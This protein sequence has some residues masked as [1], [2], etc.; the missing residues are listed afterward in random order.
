MMIDKQL[1]RLIR[2]EEKRQKEG[3]EMIPSEN[4]VSPAV[5]QALGSVLTNKYSEGYPGKRYYGGNEVIDEIEIL[6]LERAKKL[7]RVPHANVQPYSGSPANWA[8]HGALCKPHEPILSQHLSHGG[9]LS[10]GQAA[11]LSS[12][13]Y[14]AYYYGL[15]R[16]GEVDFAQLESQAGKIKPKIIWAGGT[17]YSKK[18]DWRRLGQIA[19]KIGAFFVADIAHIAGLVVGGAHPSPV[20]YAHVVTTTTHKTLRGPR[21]GMILVTK[22]GLKKDPD[23]GQKIDRAVFPGLQGGPHD[24]QIAALAVALHEAAQ[25]SFKNYA[26]QIVKNAKSLA[27]VFKKAGFVLVGGGTENHMVWVD[28]TNQE[29]DGWQAQFALEA[30]GISVN[31]QTVPYDLRSAYYP[32]GIRLGTPALTTRGMKEKEVVRIA[33]WMIEAL[34]VARQMGFTKIGSLDKEEDQLARKKFKVAV[35]VEPEINK[36]G[37]AIKSVCLKFPVF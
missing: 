30:M 10:M 26:Q 14:Q 5:R 19:D 29:I 21:G 9:H 28:L 11:N 37:K 20:P 17:A 25:P 13:F 31:R 7:F 22:K 35:K 8:V 18:F 32:S 33:T 27:S 34:R 12:Q 36:L 23:L 16:Q 1:F 4:Y 15:T 6:A 24:H 3:L 2:K